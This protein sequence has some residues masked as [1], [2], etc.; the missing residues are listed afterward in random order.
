MDEI[1]SVVEVENNT[2]YHKYYLG[3]MQAM[4]F[5]HQVM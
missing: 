1:I 5:W 4:K 2:S 3:L